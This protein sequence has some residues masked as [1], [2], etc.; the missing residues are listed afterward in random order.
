MYII[1]SIIL[2][3]SYFIQLNHLHFIYHLYVNLCCYS[4]LKNFS[5]VYAG[6][7]FGRY[8]YILITESVY[9]MVNT[10]QVK[11]S[12][13]FPCCIL[14]IFTSCINTHVIDVYGLLLTPKSISTNKMAHPRKCLIQQRTLTYQ[15]Q[16][17]TH[18]Y[19]W[20]RS[21]PRTNN[22]HQDLCKS[23]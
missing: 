6:L 2:S 11:V 9:Y 21:I 19:C 15:S 14:H 5:F 7:Y 4:S 12:C 20:H 18:A 23:L 3:L 1:S 22:T 8:G 17:G 13:I 16:M 10:H